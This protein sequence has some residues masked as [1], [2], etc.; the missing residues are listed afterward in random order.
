MKKGI[1]YTDS[2]QK[3]PYNTSFYE[4]GY[5]ANDCT[6]K[7]MPYYTH[8]AEKGVLENCPLEDVDEIGN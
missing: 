6:H 7:D 4:Q 2:C 5:C 1:F 8:V 3:C